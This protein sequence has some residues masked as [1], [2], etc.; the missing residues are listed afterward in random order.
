[1]S[2]F[3]LCARNVNADGSFGDDPGPSLYPSVPDGQSPNQSMAM[4]QASWAK[5][6]LAASTHPDGG[7]DIV[8]FVHGYNNSQDDVLTRHGLLTDGLARHEFVGVVVSFDWP[9]GN[10]ALGYLSDRS[11]ARQTAMT[12]VDGGI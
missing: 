11:K 10:I 9:C 7:G 4:D 5:A 1:M 12:L 6:V 2:A 8:F 3:V